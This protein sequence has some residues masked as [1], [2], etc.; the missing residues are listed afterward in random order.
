[1]PHGSTNGTI[2]F[3]SMMMSSVYVAF[4]LK[5]R[6][7]GEQRSVICHKYGTVKINGIHGRKHFSVVTVAL[8]QERTENF[9]GG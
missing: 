5:Q 7:K 4:P 9:K 2:F 6:I 1:M 3:I 8:I